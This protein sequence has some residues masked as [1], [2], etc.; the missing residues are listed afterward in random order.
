MMQRLLLLLILILTPI[1]ADAQNKSTLP[2][3]LTL[4]Q[5]LDIALT[6]STALRE[7]KAN[8]EQTSGQYEQAR[9]AL[10]PQLFIAARQ[11]YLTENLEGIGIFLPGFPRVLGP[12]GS[13]DAQVVFSQDLL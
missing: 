4:R 13:M 8:L 12:F 7:A 6:N 11:A 3:N 1:F 2:A 9:S 10:L 5:A